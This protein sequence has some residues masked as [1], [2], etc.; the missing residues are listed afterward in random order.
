[1]GPRHPDRVF[2][3]RERIGEEPAGYRTLT[4]RAYDQIR[5]R[6]MTGDFA[7]ST[8]FTEADLARE[9]QMSKTPVREAL[10]RLQ[11]EDFVRAIP[12]R[13]YIVAPV[14]IAEIRDL[15]GFR[16][17]IEGEAAALAARHAGPERLEELEE[18]I[19]I[20]AEN[21]SEGS[22]RVARMILI[23]NAFH[24]TI[25]L[26][27]GNRR[28]HRST[29][30]IIREFER[31]YFLEASLPEFYDPG[32]V[33]HEAV[34]EAISGGEPETARTRMKEHVDSSRRVLSKAI[35]EGMAPASS[36]PIML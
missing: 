12:R 1:M 19:R 5:T 27:A 28:L 15:F 25:A 31:F 35:S 13:G 4:D 8:P 16:A 23:N 2:R 6:I 36:M 10:V 26:G 22:E 21:D 18:L 14:Q 17:L 30:Q 33:G 32:F 34:L 7:A 24:E 29:V 20:D 11:T 3:W 9:L